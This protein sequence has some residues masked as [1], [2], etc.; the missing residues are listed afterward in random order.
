VE[1]IVPAEVK[2]TSSI[3]SLANFLSFR[4][5]RSEREGVYSIPLWHHSIEVQSSI[6]AEGDMS[7]RET[8]LD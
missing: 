1:D 3:V 7:K 4:E 6:S 2:L 5:K 8:I